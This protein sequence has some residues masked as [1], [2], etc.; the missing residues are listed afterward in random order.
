MAL[1]TKQALVYTTG[2]V[3]T[4]AAVSASDT[5]VD[6]GN[7]K[8]HFL[9][10]KNTNAAT[11]TVTITPPGATSYGGTLSPIVVVLAA[12]TGQAMIPLHPDWADATGTITLAHTGTITNTTVALV[13]TP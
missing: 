3:P 5:V 2:A 4:L 8:T 13:R 12:T 9:W 6:F 11:S 7:G 10:Y 1:L